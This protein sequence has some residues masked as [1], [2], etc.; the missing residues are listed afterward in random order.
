MNTSPRANRVILGT[1]TKKLLW[2]D[3]KLR[4]LVKTEYDV[5]YTLSPRRTE[6]R[7]ETPEEQ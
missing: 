2:F 1:R 5:I 6:G 4:H 7:A 3:P